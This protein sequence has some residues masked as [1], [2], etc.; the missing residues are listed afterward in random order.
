MRK[1]KISFRETALERNEDFNFTSFKDEKKSAFAKKILNKL[2]PVISEGF[3]KVS[4]DNITFHSGFMIVSVHS[5]NTRLYKTDL[6][7]LCKIKEFVYVSC[8]A[9]V[10]DF[11]FKY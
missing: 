11:R 9:E 10:V 4:E 1:L 6:E 5:R 2:K 7:A 3:G 8:V